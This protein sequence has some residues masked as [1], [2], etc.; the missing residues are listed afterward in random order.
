ME[1]HGD[2]VSGHM[3][4]CSF[5]YGIMASDRWLSSNMKQPVLRNVR[6]GVF[7][8]GTSAGYRCPT[9]DGEM[10]KGPVRT[11]EGTTIEVD[12]CLKCGSLWFDNREME[13]FM[14]EIREITK[15][16][17]KRRDSSIANSPSAVA[18]GLISEVFGVF[19]SFTGKKND[20]SEEE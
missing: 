12:G 9:C 2:V 6:N 3:H 4:Y 20:D 16:T 13:P 11:T 8:A 15:K 14:P 5:C 17:D 7:E 18:R 19:T 10:V 1:L